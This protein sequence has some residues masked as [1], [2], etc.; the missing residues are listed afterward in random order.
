MK[1]VDPSSRAADTERFAREVGAF[2]K[3]LRDLPTAGKEK[4][5]AC[6]SAQTQSEEKTEA[7]DFK[8]QI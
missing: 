5:A 6:G 7:I 8:D 1:P 3:R 4:G 2:S